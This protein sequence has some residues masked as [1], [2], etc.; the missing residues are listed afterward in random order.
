MF[1]HK[2]I[3][4]SGNSITRKVVH[5]THNLDTSSVGLVATAYVSSSNDS[6]WNSLNSLFYTSG[7]PVYISE[8]K[9]NHYTSNLTSGRTFNPQ[10]L[11][12]FHTNTSGSIISIT[13]EYFGEKIKPG[14]F[15]LTDKSYTDNDGNNPIIKDDSYGNLYSSNA[16]VSQS[17]LTALSSSDNYI[18]NIFYEY[19]IVT[20]TETNLWSGSTYYTEIANSS[21]FTVDFDSSYTTN[22]REYSVTLDP[23][24]FNKSMNHSL[25]CLPSGSTDNSGDAFA[26]N[27]YLCAEFTGSE[28]HPYITSIGLYNKDDLFEPVIVANFP[29]PIMKSNKVATTFKIKLDM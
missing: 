24:E 7:S 13:N 25:R 14:S 6:Y 16:H 10:N 15:V 28:W 2:N 4:K 23:D 12:K 9:F 3:D 5:Y 20:I 17:G 21:N 29:R 27:P 22:T 1:V 8:S 26:R 19:G 11:N 18:G